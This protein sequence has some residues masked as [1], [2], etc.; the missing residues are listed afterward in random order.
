VRARATRVSPEAEWEDNHCH[1]FDRKLPPL[2]D[3]YQPDVVV[4][5]VSL[6]ELADQL[7]W[8]DDAAHV[9]GDET[10]T[11]Y[12]DSEMAAL[13]GIL[14]PRGIPL[15]VTDVPPIIAGAMASEEMADPVRIAAWNAQI[16]RW[17]DAW[18]TVEV[19]EYAAPLLAYEAEHGSTRADGVHPEID[20]LT[21]IARDSY[22]PA[23]I[24]TTR[25]LLA[26]G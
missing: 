25:G 19:L 22:V 13:I 17:A 8:G 3:E 4:M 7:Y 16:Q 10:F 6:R 11:A 15:L 9:P 26:T 2:L 5:M 1:A 12:H 21:V 20:P 24:G 14:E 23:L 18:P